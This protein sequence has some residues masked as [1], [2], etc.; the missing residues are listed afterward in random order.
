MPPQPT[1][2]THTLTHYTNTHRHRHHNRCTQMAGRMRDLVARHDLSSARAHLV[3]SVPG[4]HSGRSLHAYGH[5]RVRALLAQVRVMCGGGGGGGGGFVC[6]SATCVY[7][8]V[9]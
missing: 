6:T 1:T 2:H 4:R 9:C 3:A 5:M 7:V 8:V